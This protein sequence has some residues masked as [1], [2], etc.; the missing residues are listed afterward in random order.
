MHVNMER[1]SQ[2]PFPPLGG[3][4]D[5]YLIRGFL[6]I[7]VLSLFCL[8]VIYVVIDF[9]DRI[10]SL[11]QAGATLST[12]FRYFF[13]KLPLVISRT[14]GFA[15]L[16]ATLFSLGL[17]SRNEE[18]TALRASGLSLH[19][20]TL[21][22]LLF[23]LLISVFA[24][25]WNESLVPIFTRKSQSIYKTEI[26]KTQPQS[27]VGTK[28]I[29]MRGEGSFVSVAHFDPRNNI[30]EG[31]SLYLLNRDFSLKGL[32]EAPW[33][34]WDGARWEVRGGTEWTFL[35]DSRMIRQSV[36]TS[37]PL[38]ET[39]E[40]FKLLAIEP[41][42]F[43]FS[44]LRKQITDLKAKGIDSKGQGGYPISF[45]AAGF[46]GNPLCPQVQLGRGMGPEL[47]IQHAY[48]LRILGRPSLRHLSGP[49]WGLA[50]LGCRMDSQSDSRPGRTLFLC[51]RTITSLRDYGAPSETFY[52]RPSTHQI[53]VLH[54]LTRC[55]LY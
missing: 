38:M 1:V 10:D 18:I 41:E 3:I 37:L 25:F 2:I 11:M 27:L 36:D 40:D 33:A 31:V 22:L 45:S 24:F 20:I 7:L 51:G 26:K 52:F 29:W 42:E 49:Q 12:A 4:L 44:E 13:Y 55:P 9:F 35:P 21:S 17:L 23:S 54:R 6:R 48:R 28:D 46:P 5:R 15:V 16:F 34:R 53:H 32:I 47:R 39:P 14:L 30:L 19:R 43:S 50:L 8:T